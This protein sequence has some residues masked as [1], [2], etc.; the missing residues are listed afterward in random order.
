M[1]FRA[2]D[3]AAIAAGEVTLAFRRWRR[4]TVRPG[5]TLQTPVGLLAIDAVDVVDPRAI[6]DATPGAPASPDRR[7]RRAALRG[8]GE[9]YRIELRLAGPDP[10][11]AL[12]ADAALTVADRA[13]IAA[14]LARS[15]PRAGTARGPR[16][17]C[18]R[19]SRPGHTRRGLAAGWVASGCRSR[20]TC[21]S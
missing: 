5:G 14:R 19:S 18:G 9:T 15:T 10:R 20:P 4:P 17:R 6:T 3:L 7:R 16:R 12:R 8:D 21:A 11:V 1:L 2:D 13:E